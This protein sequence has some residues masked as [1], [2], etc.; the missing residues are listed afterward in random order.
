MVGDQATAANAQI[1]H[2][3]LP[4]SPHEN[5]F[6]DNNCRTPA[7]SESVK[8][9]VT[10]STITSSSSSSSSKRKH[11]SSEGDVFTKTERINLIKDLVTGVV[12]EVMYPSKNRSH[13]K[14]RQQSETKKREFLHPCNDIFVNEIPEKVAFEPQSETK[15]KDI[16]HP[17]SDIFV[18]DV[19]EKVAFESLQSTNNNS[20]SLPDS[21]IDQ[22]HPFHSNYLG[23]TR[24]GYCPLN[25]D[26][27]GHG[28]YIY[29]GTYIIHYIFVLIYHSLPQCYVVPE[30]L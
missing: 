30:L 19:P 18:N 11:G 20:D 2:N 13:Y 17:C 28:E 25:D 5:V 3:L 22:N 15:N 23:D 16:V 8:T 21:V 14:K 7:S 4:Y 27:D 9:F 10:D 24:I 26:R 12:E 6:H 1:N 29:G